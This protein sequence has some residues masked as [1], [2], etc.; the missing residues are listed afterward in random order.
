VSAVRTSRLVKRF[1]TTVAVNEVDLA[2]EA[3][4]VRGLLG[5]NGAGKTTLLRML[6]GLIRPDAGEIELLGQPLEGS[7]SV[8]LHGVGGFVEDPAFYPYLSG[9]VNLQLLARL[10]GN[11]GSGRS[12][13]SDGS[14][15]GLE[16]PIDDALTR[17]GL[18]HR[19]DDRVGGYSTGMRQRL[20]IAAALVRSPR[21]LLLDEPTS[22]LD[23]AGAR[24][25]ATLVREL[26]AD[27]VAVLLSSHQIG[28]LERVCTGF[29]FLREGRVVWDGSAAELDAQAPVSAFELI[30]SNDEAALRIAAEREGL[31]AQLAPRGGIVLTVRPG[32]LDGYVLALGDARIAVR[33]LELR[34][35]PLESMFFALMSDEPRLDELEPDEFA[36]RVLAST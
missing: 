13:G 30:T 29:S 22:G 3:G 12:H 9:R 10:D 2:L 18:G 35:S 36:A 25:V 26:A 15:R 33:R 21:L 17:V 24:A 8:A 14:D 28:E 23:P 19:G 31:R 16:T 1:D 5:P 32:A 20:G 27:G 7:G 34:V 4:E 11:G 6:L